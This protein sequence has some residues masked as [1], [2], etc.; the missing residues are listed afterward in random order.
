MNDENDEDEV[1]T[2]V[3]LVAAA[4]AAL[5]QTGVDAAKRVSFEDDEDPSAAE[6]ELGESIFLKSDSEDEFLRR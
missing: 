3:T 2:T 1:V 5:V 6:E 4:V